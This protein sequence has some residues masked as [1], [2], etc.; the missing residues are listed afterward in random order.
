M[1]PFSKFLCESILDPERPI[2]SVAVF[3]L[4]DEPK[5]KPSVR[6]QIIARI[7]ILAKV[8]NV[9]D[10]TLIG[11]ILTRRYAEDSDIDV[12]VLVS[13]SD[14]NMENIR[15]LATKLSGHF[16]EGTKHPINL[17][18]LNDKAD[19]DNAND[20]ADGVFDISTNEFI[21]KP[22]EKPF[23]IEQYMSKFKSVVSKIDALKDD[24]KDDLLDYEEL[25]HFSHEDMKV[26]Q[27]EIET[28][29]KEIE[30][31]AQGLV[32]VYD[33]VRKE[34]ADGFARALTTKDIQEYGAKNRLPGNVIYK[35]LERHLYLNFLHKVKSIIGDDNKLSSKEADQLSVLVKTNTY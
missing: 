9:I 19:Y 26:L 33:R 6:V 24:L 12:N 32:D 20:S 18:V 30:S 13:E 10:Y 31:D 17:H 14:D 29:L 34:R 21:R 15:N 27:K 5:L 11:S 3:D 22:I 25:K 7:A 8:A 2:L 23:H 16:L 4:A 1:K 28:E 35:L